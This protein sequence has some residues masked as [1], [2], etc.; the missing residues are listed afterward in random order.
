M[1]RQRSLDVPKQKAK[2]YWPMHSNRQ[3]R[4]SNNG[5]L[6]SV[7]IPLLSF[8]SSVISVCIVFFFV[9]LELRWFI[10][11]S[12]FLYSFVMIHFLYVGQNV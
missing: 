3:W 11:S 12:P 9:H 4:A 8:C 7:L 1:L 5:L 6:L 2:E 10:D